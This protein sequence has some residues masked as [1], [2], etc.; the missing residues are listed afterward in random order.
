MSKSERPNKKELL[1]PI[2]KCPTKHKGAYTT[3]FGKV[4]CPDCGHNINKE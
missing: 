1:F 3:S 4:F 2:K